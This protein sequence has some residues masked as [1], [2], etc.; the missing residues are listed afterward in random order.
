MKDILNEISKDIPFFQFHKTYTCPSKSNISYTK[1]YHIEQDIDTWTFLSSFLIS[2]KCI[3]HSLT[4]ILCLY[5]FW[6]N[7]HPDFCF[8]IFWDYIVIEI[9]QG[10][11]TEFCFLFI[12]L[13]LLQFVSR[14]PRGVRQEHF[15]VLHVIPYFCGIP[16]H[17]LI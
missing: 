13:C 14:G 11:W 4:K 3:L 5:W 6:V 7:S 16:C 12:L 8:S 9:F 10:F 17:F 1:M 2:R 15:V